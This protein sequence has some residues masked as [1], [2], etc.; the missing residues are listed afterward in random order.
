[1]VYFVILSVVPNLGIGKKTKHY[2]HRLYEPR[3]GE[4]NQKPKTPKYIPTISIK[5]S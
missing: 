5:K 1:M 4:E 3:E 2:N